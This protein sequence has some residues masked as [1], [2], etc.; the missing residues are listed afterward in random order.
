V[1]SVLYRLVTESNEIG[2]DAVMRCTLL[3]LLVRFSV[4]RTDSTR[5]HA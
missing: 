4:A 1:S 2:K 5:S 3:Q